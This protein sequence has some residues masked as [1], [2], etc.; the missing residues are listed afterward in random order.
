MIVQEKDQPIY[1][2]SQ[3]LQIRLWHRRFGYTSNTRI[4][5]ALKL[6]DDI[7]LDEDDFT[8]ANE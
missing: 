7:D 4:I 8:N 6:V 5:G 2:Q 1:F 3:N